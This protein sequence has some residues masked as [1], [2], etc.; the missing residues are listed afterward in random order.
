MTTELTPA[1]QDALEI[2]IEQ[3]EAARRHVE[4][5]H[6]LVTQLAVLRMAEAEEHEQLEEWYRTNVKT[7]DI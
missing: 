1:V 2:A 4:K 3:L 5:M 6:A 7:I